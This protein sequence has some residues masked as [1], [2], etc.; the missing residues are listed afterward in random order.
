MLMAR[1]N[2]ACAASTL[3]LLSVGRQDRVLEIGFGPGVGIALASHVACKV[4]GVDPSPIMLEQARGRNAAAVEA[5]RVDLRLNTVDELPFD[6][7][8]FDAAY[9]VNSMQLW[10]DRAAAFSEIRRVLKPVALG[11]TPNSG[12]GKEGITEVIG[13]CGFADARLVNC[14]AG[15]VVPGVKTP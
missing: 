9:A 14:S 15:F 3:G 8:G 5:A 13:R 10:S 4:A 11:F 6:D 1:M 2:R 7:G 12:Q